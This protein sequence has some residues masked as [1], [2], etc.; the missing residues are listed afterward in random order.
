M[1]KKQDIFELLQ[2][3]LCGILQTE[4]RK[5]IG[6]GGFFWWQV[7]GI[8]FISIVDLLIL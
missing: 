7:E 4:Q 8:Y 5:M 6:Y 1:S 2:E 3:I